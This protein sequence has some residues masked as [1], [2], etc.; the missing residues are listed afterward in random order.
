MQK[1]D[2]LLLAAVIQTFSIVSLLVLVAIHAT[3]DRYYLVS[4]SGL[5]VAIVLVIGRTTSK[6]ADRRDRILGNLIIA[7]TQGVE[8]VCG[9]FLFT[10][11]IANSTSIVI[12]IAASVVLCISYS[13]K[14]AMALR[15]P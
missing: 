2:C 4:L 8:A 5:I 7:V 15:L 1:R 11:H 3:N 10:A 9:I 12:A 6:T 14:A 13:I